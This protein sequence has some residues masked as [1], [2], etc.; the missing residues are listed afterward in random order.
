MVPLVVLNSPTIILGEF[1]QT[2]IAPFDHSFLSFQV[3][4]IIHTSPGVEQF[5][6]YLLKPLDLHEVMGMAK[7]LKDKCN[8]ARSYPQL[9]FPTPRPPLQN[10]TQPVIKNNK[11][12][13][14]V[15]SISIKSL[16]PN[17]MA[18]RW[19]RGLCFNCDAKF[20]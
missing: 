7:L 8:A 3:G 1:C 14:P 5:K 16:T 2:S 12:S 4:V 17:E 11:I 15:S 13:N 10:A 18:I 19:E 9:W 20:T 6:A